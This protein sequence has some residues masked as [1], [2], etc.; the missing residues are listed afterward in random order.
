M[1]VEMTE[2]QDVNR[3]GAGRIETRSPGEGVSVEH[4]T[5]SVQTIPPL[6]RQAKRRRRLLLGGLGD[7]ILIVACVVGIP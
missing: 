6:D 1:P 4:E 2:K 3:E 5:K 7:L